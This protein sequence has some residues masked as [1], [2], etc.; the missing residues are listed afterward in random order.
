MFLLSP[1]P[2]LAPVG[3]ALVLLLPAAGGVTLAV[4]FADQ[5][6]APLQRLLATLGAPLQALPE[7]AASMLLGPYGLIAMLPFLLLYAL[8]TLLSFAVLVWVLEDSGA[9]R[10]IGLMLDPFMHRFGLSS[11]SLIPVVMG[12]GCNVPAI[13]QARHCGEC[14]RCQSAS[15]VA[16]GA[17]CSYQLPATLAVFAAAGQAWLALPY[18]L[19][20]VITSLIYLRFTGPR[21]PRPE[22]LIHRSVT[23]R[24]PE[25]AQL[26]HSLISVLGEFLRL[27]LPVF[28]MICLVA[29]LL[30]WAGVIAALAAL[31]APV[32]GLFHLPEAAAV[33][34]LMGAIRKDGIA[35]G[36]LAPEGSGLK[37]P[38][39]DAGSL[40]T[41]TYL[42]SVLLPCMVT[43]LTLLRE[44]R[45]RQCLHLL[46]RQML[47]ALGFTLV[48]AWSG[49][50]I[51]FWLG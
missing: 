17:A 16:F 35:I 29:A 51:S 32:M 6:A 12:F 49:F 20:L 8:P 50:G 4:G 2:V 47:W 39:L 30:E 40:L 26:W 9:L 33:P 1:R 36:L 3:A 43:Q 41:V 21:A 42:A 46:G 5:L 7:P 19:L 27:A 18:L 23:L 48:I 24:R 14:E 38:A 37:I 22:G 31:L 10:R 11:N 15:A 13:V 25:P 28:V 45:L 44:F 34:V